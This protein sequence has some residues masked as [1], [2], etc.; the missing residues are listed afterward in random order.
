VSDDLTG[1]TVGDRI[2][3]FIIRSTEE[4]GF[5]PTVREICDE[6]GWSS[7]STAHTHLTRL[8]EEG[9]IRHMPGMPRTLQVVR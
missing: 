9:R 6:M 1:A 7:P 5:P 8:V 4:W 3:E 2:V